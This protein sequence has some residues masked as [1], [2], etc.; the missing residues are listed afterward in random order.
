MAS[1]LVFSQ[2]KEPNAFVNPDCTWISIGTETL[3]LDHLH[4]GMARLIED[5]KAAFL[6]L[7]QQDDWP[8]MSE[9]HIIDNLGKMD[10]GYSFLEDS[11]LQSSQT[12]VLFVIGPKLE[13]W[14]I[15][16]RG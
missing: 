2:V 5:E 12:C 9:L 16:S 10:R 3:Y 13:A 8:T 7:S 15:L 6:Y 1:A 11:S 4:S 14:L